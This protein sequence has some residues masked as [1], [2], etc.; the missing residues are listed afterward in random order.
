MVLPMN[1]RYAL[2]S[3]EAQA[4]VLC[5]NETIHASRYE[6]QTV[7]IGRPVDTPLSSGRFVPVKGF[8]EAKPRSAAQLAIR[9]LRDV[10]PDIIIVEQRADLASYIAAGLPNVPVV[11]RRHVAYQPKSWMKVLR[12][13]FR[14]KRIA[15]IIWVSDAARSS[16]IN[17]HK[18]FVSKSLTIHNGFDPACWEPAIC[19]DKVVLFSGRAHPGKGVLE[20]ALAVAQ[21]LDRFKDWQCQFILSTSTAQEGYI[22]AVTSALRPLGSRATLSF[23]R[24]FDE[25]RVANQ[26]AAVVL[27]PSKEAEAFGRTALEAMAGGAT[28]VTSGQFG[29][30]EICGDCAVILPKVS[31]DHIR[32]AI[33]DLIIEPERRERIGS[34]GNERVRKLF[35]QNILSARWDRLI[36][37]VCHEHQSKKGPYANPNY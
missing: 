18:A 34:M 27:V 8:G 10:R 16:F 36:E 2:Y 37:D 32:Q 26:N 6:R 19:R 29:L 31:A 4:I 20:A 33:I 1:A 14:F 28:L 35:D 25:V 17:K 9:A 7:V 22:E 21:A 11:L 13:R 30:K 15:K 24:P 12:D 23:D 5:A 3:S